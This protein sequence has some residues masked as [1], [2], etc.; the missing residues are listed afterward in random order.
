VHFRVGGTLV[1]G[2]LVPTASTEEAPFIPCERGGEGAGGLP[3]GLFV[4]KPRYLGNI[5]RGGWLFLLSLTFCVTQ[6]NE[7]LN[8]EV[9]DRT[10]TY[11]IHPVNSFMWGLCADW[12]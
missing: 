12:N 10:D 3:S 11:A 4:H 8:L 5:L 2:T 9:D 6:G 7:S 1:G